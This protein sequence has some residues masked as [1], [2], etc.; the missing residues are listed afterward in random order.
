MIALKK[1]ENKK[2]RCILRDFRYILVFKYL[3]NKLNQNKRLYGV[4]LSN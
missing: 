1:I 3:I 2:P 4:L